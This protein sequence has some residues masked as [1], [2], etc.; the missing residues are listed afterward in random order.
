MEESWTVAMLLLHCHN[1]NYWW[2]ND[3]HWWL[4]V[5][6]VPQVCNAHGTTSCNS[7]ALVPLPDIC[8]YYSFCGAI[9]LSG[10]SRYNTGRQTDRWI[11][12]FYHGRW[13]SFMV[14]GL[15][16]SIR[17]VSLDASN[18][19]NTRPWPCPT[20]VS[21]VCFCGRKFGFPLTQQSSLVV[22]RQEVSR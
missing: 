5:I 14:D 15:C 7:F 9:H 20:R 1:F 18:Y 2:N 21:C 22:Q 13:S 12:G 11:W 3:P 10:S 16:C 4:S 17:G 6:L 19:S 8:G